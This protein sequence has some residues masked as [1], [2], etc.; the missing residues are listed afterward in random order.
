MCHCIA[1]HYLSLLVIAC[2]IVSVETRWCA[3]IQ[4]AC[5]SVV[6]RFLASVPTF[7]MHCCWSPL[8]ISLVNIIIPL[9]IRPLYGTCCMHDTLSQYQWCVDGS[10]T[11]HMMC[12]WQAT[13]HMLFFEVFPCTC[14]LVHSFHNALCSHLVPETTISIFGRFGS[15]WPPMV[16][17]ER[18]SYRPLIFISNSSHCLNQ[19][20]PR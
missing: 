11:D 16:D 8:G 5:S 15:P 19:S 20:T 4:F 6:V 17:N 18:A 14:C 12:G 13:D 10:A 2:H 9:T 7:N 1:C 3:F